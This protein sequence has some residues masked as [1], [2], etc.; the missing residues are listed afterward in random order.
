[1]YEI[2]MRH[3][4]NKI[5]WC[6]GCW[7]FLVHLALKQALSELNIDPKDTVMVTWIWCNSKINQYM[8]GYWAETLHW[9]GVPFAIGVKLANPKLTV[10]SLSWDGDTYWIWL[11]HLIHAARRNINILHI[12]CD[13]ENYALTTGQASATTPLG[14]K[15]KSTPDGNTLSPLNPVSLLESIWCWF[16]RTVQGNA[17]QELK[18]TIKQAIEYDGFSHINIQQS[19]PSWRRR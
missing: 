19:C 1:M 10:I 3:N 11:W 14:V 13:N 7:N 9:R 15:T 16:V 12:T 2:I 5:Q 6:P 17:M 4:L 8:E 18:E